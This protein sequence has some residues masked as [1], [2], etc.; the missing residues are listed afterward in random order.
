MTTCS[1]REY[2]VYV[3]TMSGA[4]QTGMDN[5]E[6]HEEPGLAQLLQA[7]LSDRQEERRLER[8][9]HEQ[10]LAQ[11]QEERRVQIDLMRAL[12]EGGTLATPRQ[13]QPDIFFRKL[14]EVDDIEAYLTTFEWQCQQALNDNTGHLS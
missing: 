14:T 9:H 12:L 5:E 4:E 10:E 13:P 3:Q 2:S 7:L 6:R 1:G 8:V 11:H